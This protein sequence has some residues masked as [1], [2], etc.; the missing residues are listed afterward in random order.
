MLLLVTGAVANETADHSVVIDERTLGRPS[1][2]PNWSMVE[3]CL[4]KRSRS[5]ASLELC[6]LTAA[7]CE[8]KKCLRR[9]L[10]KLTFKTPV[11]MS[12]E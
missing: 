6:I 1:L 12:Y 8:Y 4:Q 5:R 10:E 9:G 3:Q 2:H 11:A 7:C